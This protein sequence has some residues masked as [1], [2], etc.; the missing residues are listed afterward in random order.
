MA[1]LAQPVQA[2]FERLFSAQLDTP[3]A[4][5]VAFTLALADDRGDALSGC[6]LDV[7]ADLA[8]QA[9]AIQAEKPHTLRFWA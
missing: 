3:I 4:Q 2:W 1:E 6:Y 8:A 5:A 7:D 9:G